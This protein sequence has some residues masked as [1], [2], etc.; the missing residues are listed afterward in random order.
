MADDSIW[1]KELSFKRKP[2]EETDD[3][4]PAADVEESTS[5][6][7]KE[8]S[9]KKSPEAEN[10]P[11]TEAVVEE[12][13]GGEPLTDEPVAAEHVPGTVP[14][15]GPD[16][17][18][19][20]KEVS[21]SR[22]AS[23][24]EPVAE[25]HVSAEHV[26]GT[27]P[28]PG[29]DETVWKTEVS[30]AR[31]DAEEPVVA[32][33]PVPTADVSGTVPEPGPDETVWK[34]E[35]SFERKPA[36]AEPALTQEPMTSE[37][38]VAADEPVVAEESVVV[39]EPVVLEE[40][41]IAEESIVAEEPVFPELVA[42]EQ[43]FT[44]DPEPWNAPP[45]LP[46]LPVVDEGAALDAPAPEAAVPPLPAAELPLIPEMTETAKVPF[47][48]K[49]ISLGGKKGDPKPKPQKEKKRRKRKGSEEAPAVDEAPTV[50]V[51]APELVH[52]PVPAAELPPLPDETAKVPFW[53]KEIGGKK[54][55][56][57]PKEKKE[58]KPKASKEERAAE[59]KE[60]KQ[61][62][63]R[64]Q[65]VPKVKAVRGVKGAKGITGLKI[66]ASQLAAARVSN[67]GSAELLQVAR[68]PL[69]PGIV[70]GGELRDPDALAE[71]LKDF[72]AKNGLPKRG[73]RLGLANNRIGVRTFEISG[74]TD[75]KQLGNA[76]R[77][78]AQEALPIPIDE[79]VLD[80][81]VL[82]EGVDEEGNP[83]QRILLVVAYRE[84]I[85]RY[86]DACKKAGIILS[87]IDLEAFA[88]L[89]AL[90][91]PQDGVGSDP[92]AA[93]VAVAIGHERSTFAVSDGRVCEFTRVLDWGGSALNVAIA[94]AIDAAPS[95][96]EGFK[97]ALALTD[98]MVPDGLNADQAK[99]AREAIRRAIQ[100]FARELVSSLQ[101]YQNQPGSLGI[102]EIVLTGGT[103]HLPGI[104]GELERMI[105]VRVRVGDPL[106]RMKVSKKVGEPEQ[107]GSLA[108]AI[109]LGIED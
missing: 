28:E 79:A 29:P 100:N 5:L 72:F 86:V 42:L 66:G 77:F 8:L 87:G 92:S 109:G 31:Q 59:T 24:D 22:K 27:V 38:T 9:L 49:E 90:Q 36:D 16:E 60:P 56:R 51:P 40:P 88:L 68:E 4:P 57:K 1:K 106:A 65:K 14:G 94:R 20:K 39:D 34:K 13:P 89:R 21:F 48:K 64:K 73:V 97:R 91:A 108:V 55:D 105:G 67:N 43:P 103:A 32:E 41:V 46:P 83:T 25:E 18:V 2:K 74:I 35:V 95:E 17:P 107:I 75:P 33:E 47:W 45:A 26:P 6:W 62:K 19:W 10:A 61:P 93:L 3:A 102:G 69:A 30:F 84:L 81:Q 63:E 54:S 52:P 71:A 76:V 70:V 98:E 101:Y 58:R 50:S 15:T 78:R 53:K 11:E 23:Q 12:T 7:K 80:Y 37:D 96:V 85:D 104:S 99:K 44:V 82:G